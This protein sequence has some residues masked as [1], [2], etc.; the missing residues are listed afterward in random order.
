MGAWTSG[1]V[2]WISGLVGGVP[3][4]SGRALD[5]RVGGRALNGWIGRGRAVGGGFVVGARCALSGWAGRG[6][7]W[8]GRRGLFGQPPATLMADGTLSPE[9]KATSGLVNCRLD[10]LPS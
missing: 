8:V 1:G 9:V 7:P 3:W 4:V 10:A 6:V 5:K 2:P